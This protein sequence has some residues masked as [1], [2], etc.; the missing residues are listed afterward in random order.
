MNSSAKGPRGTP[1]AI[2]IEISLRIILAI[3]LEIPP[4]LLLSIFLQFLGLLFLGTIYLE[5]SR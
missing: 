2:Y 4:A 3:A 5:F 1:K